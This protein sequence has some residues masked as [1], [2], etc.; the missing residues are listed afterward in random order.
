MSNLTKSIDEI[1]KYA[2]KHNLTIDEVIKNFSKN[3]EKEKKEKKAKSSWDIVQLARD[4][5]K[6]KTLDLI[7]YIF[8]DFLQMHGDRLYGDDKAIVGGIA[9]LN[10]EPVTVIGHQKGTTTDENIERNFGMAHP[11]GYRKALRLMKQADKFNRPI[12]TFIDTPGAFCGLEAEKRGQ[13]EAIAKNLFEMADFDVPI[14]TIII[15]EGGSGGA[16]GLAVANDVWMLQ[17]SIYSVI[18]PEGFSSILLKDASK[19]SEATDMMKIVPKEL[20]RLGLIDKII[21]EPK[22]NDLD[23]IGKNLKRNIEVIMNEYKKDKDWV[24]KRYKKFREYGKFNK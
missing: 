16:L 1:K 24:E 9:L 22:R 3:K 10:D 4:K 5:N 20:K 12:I 11:E 23:L 18:S 7:N 2:N 15:G 8:D 17:N 21:K 19:A 14:L 13:S 6:P